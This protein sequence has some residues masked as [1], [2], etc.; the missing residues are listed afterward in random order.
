VNNHFGLLDQPCCSQGQKIR[1][2]GPCAD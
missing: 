2:T 1:V